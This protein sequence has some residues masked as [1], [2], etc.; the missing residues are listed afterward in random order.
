MRSAPHST[1]L[2]RWFYHPFPLEKNPLNHLKKSQITSPQPLS[3]VDL[4][5][6]HFTMQVQLIKNTHKTWKM[7]EPIS[8]LWSSISKRTTKA[9]IHSEL[10]VSQKRL[11]V[12]YPTLRIYCIVRVFQYL[13]W[14]LKCS[15]CDMHVRPRLETKLQC[16]QIWV[17]FDNCL[18][19]RHSSRLEKIQTWTLTPLSFLLVTQINTS[20]VKICDT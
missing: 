15:G 5:K 4:W 1:A 7:A 19:E 9:N 13:K 2:T 11:P 16:T 18:D 12:L 10:K 20:T 14:R 3:V 8:G 17:L 6:H